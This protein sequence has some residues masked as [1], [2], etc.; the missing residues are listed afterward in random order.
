MEGDH[1]DCGQGE[2]GSTVIR[3]PCTGDQESQA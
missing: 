1:D 2:C 3:A